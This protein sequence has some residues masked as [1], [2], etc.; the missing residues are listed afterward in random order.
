[1][2]LSINARH[3][4]LT[5][6]SLFK[7]SS[8]SLSDPIDIANTFCKYFTN[9]GPD[10]A[11]KIPDTNVSYRSFLNSNCNESI[12]LRPTNV[13]EL[14]EICSLFKS[15]KAP[16]YD[17]ISMYTIRRSFDLLAEPLANSI[18]LSLSKGIFLDK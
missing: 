15:E 16:G 6:P 14:Q 5:L 1:M 13:N 10:L 17:N 12:F 11:R 4:N 2:N 7:T 3:H 8:C 18:N 9:I